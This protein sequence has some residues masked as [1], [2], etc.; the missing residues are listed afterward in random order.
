MLKMGG[1]CLRYIH[2]MNNNLM[3]AMKQRRLTPNKQNIGA[4]L[5]AN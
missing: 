5:K 2:R 3:S 1:K 4:G